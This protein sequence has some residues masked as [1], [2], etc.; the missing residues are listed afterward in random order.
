MTRTPPSLIDP[1]DLAAVADLLLLARMVVAGLRS[2]VHRSLHTGTSAEFA[3][4]R[5]YVRGDDPR[6]VDWRL[7]GRTDRFHVRQHQAET[8][9]RCSLLLDCSGS[10]DYG[11]GAVDKFTYARMLAASLALL[12]SQQGDQV[13]FAAYDTELRAYLPPRA[14]SGQLQRMLAELDGLRPSGSTDAEEALRFI[15]DAL[16]A[17]GMIVLISD[18]LHPIDAMIGHLRSLRARRHDVLVLQISD[19]AEQT[20]PFQRALTLADAEDGREQYTVPQAVRQQYLDNRA[21]HFDR[22]AGECL[23]AEIDIEEFSCAEPLDRALHRFLHR[24]SRLLH[25]ASRRQGRPLSGRG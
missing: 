5:P 17:H 20:F 23:A 16:P 9:M 14:H 11:S 6:F 3:Q 7:Y 12:A 19:P 15:G 25:T 8:T 10:M 24:R 22:I 13:G 1:A 2:G 4:Y 18:L 21:H